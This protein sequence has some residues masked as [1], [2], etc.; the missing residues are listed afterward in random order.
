MSFFRH[1]RFRIGIFLAAMI[2]VAGGLPG[3]VAAAQGV[4]LQAPLCTPNGPE[5]ARN[6]DPAGGTDDHCQI[7]PLANAATADVR[8]NHGNPISPYVLIAERA[9]DDALPDLSVRAELMPLN[10]RAPPIQ[11]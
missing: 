2:F 1:Y 4:Q 6:S 8:N 10:G 7:C 9:P 11:S 3:L 5:P